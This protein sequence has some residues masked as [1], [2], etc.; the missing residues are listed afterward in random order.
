[1]R[2]PGGFKI[3]DP[4]YACVRAV[5][6]VDGVTTAAGDAAGTTLVDSALAGGAPCDGL[7]VKLLDTA[8]AGQVRGIV[9]HAP[10][11]ATLGVDR[12]FTNSAGAPVQVPV[13][14]HY[15]IL[16]AESLSAALLGVLAT[17]NPPSLQET[18]QD[19][20]GI[21]LTVWAPTDPATGAAWSRGAAGAYLRATSAPNAAENARLRSV[22]RWPAAP[23]L[24]SANMVLRRLTLE[25]ELRL[26]GPANL[27]NAAC[28]WG[29]TPGVA[30]TRATAGIIGWGL[31]G[32]A[33]QSV[34]DL[35]GVE[36]VNTGFGEVLTNW[37]KFRLEVESGRAAF[38]LNERLVA[39]HVANLPDG[40][41][42]LDFYTATGGGGA[43]TVEVGITRAAPEARIGR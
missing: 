34:T 2:L 13:G 27:D 38:Y 36:T 1:M 5:Y 26:T 7:L 8:A 3:D 15:V 41:F 30:D 28:F 39:A 25:F 33:L 18:W 35:A 17:G 6:V 11:S 22:Q 9:A 37:N 12:P 32:G 42:Y 21:D 43:A 20:A 14:A 19:E 31:V 24:Y 29:L 23:T 16:A 4:G 10:G 40:A